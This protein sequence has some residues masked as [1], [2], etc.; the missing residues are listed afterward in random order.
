[1]PTLP[2][3]RYELRLRAVPALAAAVG[4]AATAALGNWQLNRAHEKAALLARYLERARA[5]AIVLGRDGVDAQ[6]VEW[7]RVAARGRFDASHTIYLDNRI[8]HGVPGYDVIT[9]FAIADSAQT[10]LVNRGWVAAGPDRGRLPTVPTPK[11]TV[12][13]QGIAVVPSKR[14]LELSSHVV[15]GRVWQ[16]LSLE[17]YSEATGLTVAPIVIREQDAAPDGL[18]RDWPAPD[19]G[20]RTHLGYAFQWYALACAILVYYLVTHV[21]RKETA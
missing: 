10:V 15:E 14:Y 4:I 18:V 20:R 21:R 2:L 1:M 19:Y 6:S 11:T 16:N 5:P 3:G 12:T 17:R 7:R 9:P 13:V 8:Y